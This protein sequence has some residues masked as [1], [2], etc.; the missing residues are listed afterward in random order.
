VIITT[1][2]FLNGLIHIGSTRSEAGRMGEFPSKALPASLGD[3]KLAMG[4]LKTGTVPR[5]D[6][7]TVRWEG[8]EE[9]LGDDPI[10]K[11]SFWDS[12][13]ELPQVS[14]FITYTN[15]ATHRVIRE[16]LGQ[17]ALY[18]GAIKGVGPRYCPSIEDKVVKF[19]DK[20]RHQVFLEPTGL[21]SNEIYPNGL[22]TSLPPEVQLAYLRT[23]PGL[24]EVEITRP[25]YAVEYDYVLPLQLHP[26]LALKAVPNLFL[27][28]QINGTTGYEEAAAQGLVAGI[29]AALQVRGEPPFVLRRDEAYIGVLIDDLITKGTDEPYRMFT[30]RAEYRILLREDNADLRL[31]DRGYRIGLLP[32]AYWREVQEKRRRI[33][34]LGDALREIRITPT[35]AV[36]AELEG[37][38]Q[39]AIK[40]GATA[41]DLVKRPQMRLDD[42][43]RFRPVAEQVALSAFPE[44]VREQVEIGIKYEG[45]VERQSAQLAVFDRLESI[46]LPPGLEFARL[47]G[48][49]REVVQKLERFRPVNL[50]QASRISGITPAAISILAAHLKSGDRSGRRAS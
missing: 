10:R 13:I 43:A 8:L 16:N 40:T 21:D 29:N 45:Y 47:A 37:L 1:G 22:S 11:F 6:K 26:S 39:P 9:Q 3:L 4:R 5:L 30:S 36:N 15:E 32:E 50:G 23:I 35:P 28:G 2:T 34:S 12:R 25:G 27:A 14:C 42:L 17:S 19:P 49:S 48:L 7:R 38:G 44:P 31:S 20:T 24:E 18:S 46:A 41:A 33:R